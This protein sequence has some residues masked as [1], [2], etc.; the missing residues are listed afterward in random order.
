MNFSFTKQKQTHLHRKQ[1]YGYQRE[2]VRVRMNK[3]VIWD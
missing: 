1:L 3:L 2:E